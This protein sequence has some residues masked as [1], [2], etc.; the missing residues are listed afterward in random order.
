MRRNQLR[1]I[2]HVRRAVHP[3]TDTGSSRQPPDLAPNSA[4]PASLSGPDIRERVRAGE[5][6]TYLVPEGVAH[7]IAKHGLYAASAS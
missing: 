5:P 7:L 1:M 6:I 3:H 4:P 2:E